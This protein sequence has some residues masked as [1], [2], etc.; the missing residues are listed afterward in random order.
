MYI[1]IQKCIQHCENIKIRYRQNYLLIYIYYILYSSYSYTIQIYFF[2]IE[3]CEN[4]SAKIVFIHIIYVYIII[5]SLLVAYTM[6]ILYY[7]Y[8]YMLLFIVSKACLYCL[9]LLYTCL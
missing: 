9:D 5:Y 7:I 1:I 3:I 2:Y 6:T 8:I 4:T